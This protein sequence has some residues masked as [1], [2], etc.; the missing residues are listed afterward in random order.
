MW[1]ASGRRHQTSSPC[2]CKVDMGSCRKCC[3][4][5]QLL[6]CCA[7]MGNNNSLPHTRT[8]YT[9]V[10]K[11]IPRPYHSCRICK[12]TLLVLFPLA[13]SYNTPRSVIMQ[14]I[15][16]WWS[17]RSLRGWNVIPVFFCH[18]SISTVH[19]ASAA[20]PAECHLDDCLLI[21]LVSRCEISN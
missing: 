4:L 12:I 1:S 15:K 8:T 19:A 13:P 10:C 3:V 14:S 16:S 17:N 21:V 18:L 9:V 20:A 5:N 11:C 2:V 7:V 6:M